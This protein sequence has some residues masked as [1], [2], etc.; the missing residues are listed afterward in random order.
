ML[1]VIVVGDGSEEEDFSAEHI[2]EI[3]NFGNRK[4]GWQ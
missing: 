2:N 1:F 4:Y 3:Y